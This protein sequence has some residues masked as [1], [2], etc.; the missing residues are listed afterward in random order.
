MHDV[1]RFWLDRGVDGFRMDA[2]YYIGKDPDLRDNPPNPGGHGPLHKSMGEFDT[3]LHVHN[4]MHP[5][6]HAML[7]DLRDLLEQHSTPGHEKVSIGEMHIFDWSVLA[8]YYGEELDEL[9]LPFNFGLLGVQ[10][11]AG[12]VRELVDAYEAALPPGAWPN[13]VLGNHDEGRIAS[14]VGALHAR[15]AALLLFTL[16]GTPTLYYADE[17]GLH[18][19]PVPPEREQDPWG[20]NVPGLS[21]DPART[22]MPWDDSANAGFCPP[23]VEP[24]LP[25]NADYPTLNVTAEQADPRS[26]L[27]LHQRLLAL[28]RA[29]PA[30]HAGSYR[31]LTGAGI[32]EECYVYLRESGAQRALV[33]LNFSEFEQTLSAPGV[34]RGQVAI[35]THLD[36]AED[37]DLVAFRLRPAEG[38]VILLAEDA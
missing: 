10:W 11:D 26:M 31:P 9:H 27:A 34:A 21:R 30:L 8:S 5:D 3:L 19:V 2:L 32:P 12:A 37:T 22:P 1:L 13:Y 20:K 38:C 29:T 36:R 4:R 14:R 35:S 16:R 18:D 17:L 7:R 15:L 28:R 6:M 23:D 33:A 24:W 25:L